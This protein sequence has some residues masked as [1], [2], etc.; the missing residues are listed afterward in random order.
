M[1]V[2]G[3][4]LQRSFIWKLAVAFALVGIGDLLFFQWELA[5]GNLGIYGLAL[6]AGM[7]AARQGVRRDR[8]A[9][10]ATV[11]ATLFA[12]AMIYDASLLAWTLFWVAAGMAA[13]LPAS[14]HFDDGW[15]WFQRL[16]LHGLRT[17]FA[18]ILDARGV[19]KAKRRRQNSR[20]DL[21]AGIPV[22]MLPL[23]GSAIILALFS[24]ANPV[25]EQI[26]ASIS[27]P[28]L[29]FQ[30]IA[31]MMLW[32]VLFIAAWS[33]I[34]PRLA[35]RLLPTFDGS[36]DL[37]MP[38]VS[39]A[40]VKLSL[41]AFNL[42]FAMQNLMDAAY[43]SGAVPMPQ[44]ITL[45]EYAHRGA[46]PLI[47]TALLAALFVIVTLRPGSSTAAV[48][49][50]RRLVV[51]WIAQN[52]LLV[53][54]SILRLLDYVEAYSLTVLRISALAWMLLVAAGLMLICWRLLRAK[55]A[56]WL[57]N[58]NLTTAALLLA[59]VSLI[60]LGNAAA[61]WNIRHAR[62]AGGKGAALDL[63]YLSELG[64]SSLLPL[65]DLEKNPD[66][67]PA[68]RERVQAVRSDIH[69]QLRSQMVHAWTMRGEQRLSQSEQLIQTL[70]QIPLKPAMRN[71]DGS[72]VPPQPVISVPTPATPTTRPR[73]EPTASVPTPKPS[74]TLTAETRK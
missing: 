51:L 60:D 56:S 61:W 43:L 68:F 70:H 62:E 49:M 50:I 12:F 64:S 45:A 71:C 52:I 13:L 53:G 16:L 37:D 7:I 35:Q 38:G 22:L 31:R 55:S 69:R 48:P 1:T 66:L 19:L 27:V 46:Y 59:V 5:G 9:L 26:L 44:G 28:E 23:I 73:P 3:F 24:A 74:T 25:I 33:L 20:L 21:R 47:M 6:L 17:P 29:S 32:T 40:S 63:C 4:R 8:R 18:P 58:A 30:T 11:A 72:V 39:I 34:H 54:S 67:K 57:I 41:I 10:F 36:G 65:I 14:G 2:S 15:R 42:L